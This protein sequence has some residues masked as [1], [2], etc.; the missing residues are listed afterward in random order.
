LKLFFD[1]GAFIARF[2]KKDQYHNA[3]LSILKSISKGELPYKKF[4]T[5]NYV[6]QEAVTFVL[7]E[8]GNH[9]KALELLDYLTKSEYIKVLWVD[10]RVQEKANRL[11]RK[12]S[13]QMISLT[14]C[15]SAALMKENGIDT[16]FAFDD[17]F[18]TLG[19]K[20]VP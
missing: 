20:V 9:S 10:E 14:D 2:D 13:D 19:F 16:I 18:K 12:Y 3:A 5:S 6:L 17:H 1:T 8:T 4:Y 15:A 7:Y 11:F